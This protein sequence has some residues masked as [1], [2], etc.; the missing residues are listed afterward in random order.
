MESLLQQYTES[1]GSEHGGIPS[2]IFQ[3]ASQISRENAFVNQS[4][5]TDCVEESTDGVV[6]AEN[7][8]Q[9]NETGLNNAGVLDGSVDDVTALQLWDSIMTN[10][11]VA[12][13]CDE[14]LH[15]LAATHGDSAK[16]DLQ[17]LN[18][19]TAIAVAVDA[20]S[21]LQHKE[22]KKKLKELVEEQ[23]KE[24]CKIQTVVHD[25]T[26]LKNTDPAFWFACFVRLF[27]RGDCAERCRERAVA[28]SPWQWVRCLLKRADA[29]QWRTNVEFVAAL[30]CV[31]AS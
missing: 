22:V 25:T 26:F 13:Q 7:E 19:A 11:K 17:L 27:P 31:F 15:R 3:G 18:R 6:D 4:G 12:Q 1:V 16:I 23:E 20:L 28:L 9:D 24:V 14:E 2:E 5:P 29:P 8:Q 30:Q 10:Y 21:K